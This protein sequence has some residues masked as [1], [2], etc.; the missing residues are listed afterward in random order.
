ML[1][2]LLS[3]SKVDRRSAGVST[4]TV[5]PPVLEGSP[6]KVQHGRFFI[7]DS[8]LKALH[9]RR[10]I[11][12]APSKELHPRNSV[13]GAKRHSVQGAGRFSI[14]RAPSKKIL[15][16]SSI[17]GASSKELHPR[18]FIIQGASS[19]VLLPRSFIIQGA[20]SK[21][22][23]PRS[24]KLLHRWRPIKGAPQPWDRQQNEH[25]VELQSCRP[26]S[27]RRFTSYT[28]RRHCTLFIGTFSRKLRDMSELM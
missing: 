15:P 22:L 25:I 16:R 10:F 13:E 18:S 12:G 3:G 27:H 4:E 14:Q 2:G 5:D 28:I 21:V 8:P 6:W 11:Q 19:K 7:Q 9:R 26:L 24:W 20:S 1:H 23:L 17:Q